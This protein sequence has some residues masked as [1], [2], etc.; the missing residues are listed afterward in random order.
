MYV[1]ARY[2]TFVGSKLGYW[3]YGYYEWL[4]FN[5]QQGARTK[6]AKSKSKTY[7]RQ[8]GTLRLEFKKPGHKN[9]VDFPSRSHLLD[10]DQ[11]LLLIR[12]KQN[13]DA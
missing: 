7:I 13:K 11:S 6:Q 10:Q 4:N 2:L 12:S 9:R 5:A 1:W 8:R 3:N